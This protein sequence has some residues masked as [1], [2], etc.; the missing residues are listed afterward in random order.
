MRSTENWYIFVP[1]APVPHSQNE[2]R[3]GQPREVS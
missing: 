2:Q 1:M 3:Y